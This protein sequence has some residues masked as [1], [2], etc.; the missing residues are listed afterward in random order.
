MKYYTF[1]GQN[2]EKQVEHDIPEE[3][4]DQSAMYREIL[5]DA[6]SSFDDE[7]AEKFL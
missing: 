7:L 3:M 6:A 5:I 2:G 1:E 4:K